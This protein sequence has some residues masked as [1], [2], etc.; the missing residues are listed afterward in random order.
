MA[1]ASIAEISRNQLDSPGIL[2]LAIANHPIL[3]QVLLIIVHALITMLVCILMVICVR[4]ATI[5]LITK[6]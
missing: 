5:S 2:P 1:N 6:Q 4:Y 3:G